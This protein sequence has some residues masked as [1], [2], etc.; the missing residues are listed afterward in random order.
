MLG[1][2]AWRNSDWKYLTFFWVGRCVF[3][4][5][6]AIYIYIYLHIYIYKLNIMYPYI[7][8]VLFLSKGVF[9]KYIF[10]LGGKL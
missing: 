8:I 9:F 2:L 3:F 6:G 1:C 7:Y 4:F 10:W 5:G